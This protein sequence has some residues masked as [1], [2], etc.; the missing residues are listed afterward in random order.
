M[1]L[2]HNGQYYIVSP[3]G[4]LWDNENYYL[5]GY[6]EN[7]NI[8]KHFRVDKMMKISLLKEKRSGKEL[9]DKIVTQL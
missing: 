6:D 7:G 1:E 5:I 8:L 9:F 3:W 4:M 2:R